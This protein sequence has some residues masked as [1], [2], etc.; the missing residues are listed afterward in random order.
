MEIEGDLATIHT[1][2]GNLTI[3]IGDIQLEAPSEVSVDSWYWLIG[4]I[5]GGFIILGVIVWFAVRKRPPAPP[6]PP[7]PGA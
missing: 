7:T 6:P 1:D 5:L 3:A 4:P 2:L